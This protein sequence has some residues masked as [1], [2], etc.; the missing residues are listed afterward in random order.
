MPHEILSS[1]RGDQCL[2]AG[3]CCHGRRRFQLFACFARA[4][5]VAFRFSDVVV[6]L[7]T[8]ALLR[9]TCSHSHSR[10][11]FIVEA[12]TSEQLQQNRTLMRAQVRHQLAA[13]I[14]DL[15]NT[16]ASNSQLASLLRRGAAGEKLTDDEEFQFRLRSNALLRYWED[17]HYE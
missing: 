1:R 4:G 2:V 12:K 15:L 6:P 3:W 16:P 10:C 5:R 9:R 11:D 8:I 14:V 13:T 17:V 7:R